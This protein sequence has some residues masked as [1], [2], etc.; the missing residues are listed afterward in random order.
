ME[1][2]TENYLGHYAG[3]ASRLIAYAIDTVIAFAGI[4]I[5]WWLITITIEL[6]NVPQVM[7]AL[8]WTGLI[9]PSNDSTDKLILRSFVYIFGVGF[10]QVFFL[11]VAN[12]TIGKALMG[13][14]VV[15]LKGGRM[16]LIRATLR[17]VGYIIS[18]IPLFFGFFW[19]LFSARRQGWHDHVA[20]TCVVYTWEAHPDE[21]FLRRGLTR[22]QKANEKKFGQPPEIVE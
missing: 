15:P 8:G 6:L 5:L 1:T 17:Y 12:R 16:N 21:V 7:N 9:S 3:F 2:K 18:I 13:L 4:T 19:I 10:Y 20:G 22:L 11:T 14:Q